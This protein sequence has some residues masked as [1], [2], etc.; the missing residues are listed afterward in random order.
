M[1]WLLDRLGLFFDGLSRF[2]GLYNL[3]GFRDNLLSLLRI[4]GQLN[5]ELEFLVGG[6]GDGVGH[7]EVRVVF[8]FDL[9]VIRI[10]VGEMY[11]DRLINSSFVAD[12]SGL[13]LEFFVG[14]NVGDSLNDG[15]IVEVKRNLDLEVGNL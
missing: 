2:N 10:N 5:G 13:L 14:L 3:F 11:L 8:D 6:E 4:S 7:L 1:D 15:V 9:F 12:I